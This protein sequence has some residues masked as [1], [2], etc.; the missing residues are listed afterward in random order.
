MMIPYKVFEEG[1]SL[2]NLNN[3]QLFQTTDDCYLLSLQ[4]LKI[5]Q[6]LIKQKKIIIFN[7]QERRLK[8]FNPIQSK[9]NSEVFQ[10][11]P[12]L[13]AKL[14]QANRSLEQ[15]I[16]KLNEVQQQL[17]QKEEE[18]L[19]LKNLLKQMTKEI[20]DCTDK[21]NAY[22][23]QMKGLQNELKHKEY[24]KQRHSD[25]IFQDYQQVLIQNQNYQQQII[26][27][28]DQI[29]QI[30]FRLRE[31][32]HTI[33]VI[34]ET[35]HKVSYLEQD[36]DRLE[37]QQKQIPDINNQLRSVRQHYVNDLKVI[38]VGVDYLQTQ[39]IKSLNTI[40]KQINLIPRSK[41]ILNIKADLRFIGFYDLIS[42]T[43]NKQTQNI[44]KKL[45]ISESMSIW[46]ETI[47]N[48][49]I[50]NDFVKQIIVNAQE[51]I[52]NQV[53]RGLE[54]LSNR[55]IQLERQV[56]QIATTYDFVKFRKNKCEI[57]A[58][59][60]HSISGLS[61]RKTCDK[62]N[63]DSFQ[64]QRITDFIENALNK[65]QDQTDE[66]KQVS[67][68]I[69]L[70]KIRDPYLLKGVANTESLQLYLTKELIN[71]KK[72]ISSVKKYGFMPKLIC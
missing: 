14:Y 41:N 54:L 63:E 48:F 5:K 28:Q 11:S 2:I 34:K 8:P 52:Y 26:E 19:D 72:E 42:Q 24:T 32:E 68:D 18:I 67:R 60:A 7:N 70:N 57:S 55:I 4:K 47:I 46:I 23:Q 49:A 37:V 58:I 30:S 27:L 15:N 50:S 69:Q 56:V 43:H 53:L 33:M 40:Q 21:I 17:S 36:I 65:L 16:I 12:E 13:L 62:E 29:N 45:N 61:K 59:S 9:R 35:E 51:L 3:A 39:F 44:L 20:E 31:S 71:I 38:S 22:R 25:T 66:L 10:Q 6:Y 1:N 64:T